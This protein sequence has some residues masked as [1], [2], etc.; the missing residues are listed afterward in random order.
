MTLQERIVNDLKESLKSQK[1]DYEKYCSLKVIVGEL[2]RQTKKE[3]SDEE[4]TNILKRL[5]KYEIEK[6]SM[7]EMA[8]SD[9]L[10]IVESYLPKQ[11]GEKEIIKWIEDNVDFSKFNNKLQAVSIVMKEFKNLTSGSVV[12]RVIIQKFK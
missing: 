6:L 3:L 1:E 12:K 9:Y 5:Q 8:E 10:N 2:Q 11:A 7:C 4:V